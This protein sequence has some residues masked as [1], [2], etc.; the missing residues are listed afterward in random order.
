MK[1]RT[2]AAAAALLLLPLAGA[3]DGARGGEVSGYAELAYSETKTEQSG[4]GDPPFSSETDFFRQRYSVNFAQNLFPHVTL[5]LGGL[6]ERTDTQVD[7]DFSV[8]DSDDELL[9]PYATLSLRTPY[10]AGEV[11]F[12]RQ[13]RR[14]DVQGAPAGR[15]RRDLYRSAVAWTPPR[16]PLTRLEVLRAENR[17][18]PGLPLTN[19]EDLAQLFSEFRRKGLSTYYRGSVSHRDDRAGGSTVESVIHNARVRYSDHW[20]GGRMS[21]NGDAAVDYS[22]NRT[23]SSGLAEVE[24]PVLAIEGLAAID[25]TPELDPLA[26]NPLLVDDDVEASAGIDLGLPPPA[27]NDMPRNIGL[28]LGVDLPIDTLRV[29]IDIS[30]PGSV[31][32]SFTWRVYTSDDNDIWTLEHTLSSVLLAPFEDHFELRFAEI[33]ARYVK[34]VVEPLEPSVPLAINFPDIL[35]TE[36]DA[37]LHDV[38]DQGPTSVETSVTGQRLNLGLRTR[39]VESVPLYHELTYFL[40]DSNAVASRYSLTN[41]ISVADRFW[42]FYSVQARLAR[43]D[44]RD[45]TGDVTTHSLSTSL[46][47]Q[48]LETLRHN[49]VV[50]GIRTERE[51]GTTDF[52]SVILHNYVGVRRGIELALSGGRSYTVNVEDERTRVDLVNAGV[53][54]EPHPSTTVNLSLQDRSVEERGGGGAGSRRSAVA[55]LSWRPVPAFYLFASRSAA[56]T[57]DLPERDLDEFVVGWSPFPDGTLQF[58]VSYGETSQSSPEETQKRLTPSVRWNIAPGMYLEAS[59]SGFRDDAFPDRIE[60]DTLA[61]TFRASY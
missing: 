55:S 22:R 49:L 47:V 56:E 30:L 21:F 11:A 2:H 12:E 60:T 13:Q 33:E 20:W 18:G 43:S 5:A 25:D 17:A 50:S 16:L 36:V 51:V 61:A 31:A 41:G 54:L 59:Y 7:S 4:A 35:V 1:G 14:V 19:V 15:S 37:F 34:V 24:N 9:Y 58:T 57:D 39:L 53:A 38:L 48:P 23:E 8:V 28:D 32:A 29:W 52:A 44:S 45:S 6:F 46:G 40:V 27:G 42:Q 26:A 10:Y 3:S